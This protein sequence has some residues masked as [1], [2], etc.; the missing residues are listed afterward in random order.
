MTEDLLEAVIA[1]PPKIHQGD[2]EI[3]DEKA[4]TG[5]SLIGSSLA[6]Q[7]RQIL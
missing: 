3:G 6:G 5:L 4:M 1:N 7:M 2:A